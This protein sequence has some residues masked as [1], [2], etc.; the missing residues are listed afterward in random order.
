M[1][2]VP[3]LTAPRNGRFAPGEQAGLQWRAIDRAIYYEVQVVTGEGA[4]MWLQRTETTSLD[5]PPQ[6]LRTAGTHYVTVRAF[7][8][9]GR[10]VKSRA[11]PIHVAPMQ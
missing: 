3:E 5:V 7:L 2:A 9:D 1:A 4:V 8:P 6:V 11:T 10:S